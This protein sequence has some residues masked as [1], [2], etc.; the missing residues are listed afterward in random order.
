MFVTCMLC[1]VLSLA[2][3]NT[4][5][6]H[7]VSYLSVLVCYCAVWCMTFAVVVQLASCLLHEEPIAI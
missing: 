2:T 4:S 1:H 5:L 3:M 7:T 6:A